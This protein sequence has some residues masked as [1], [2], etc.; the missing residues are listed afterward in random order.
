MYIDLPAPEALIRLVSVDGRLLMVKEIRS[1][2]PWITAF[3]L[4]ITGLPEGIC[5]IHLQTGQHNPFKKLMIIK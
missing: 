1:G 3:P 2:Y 4:D 5:F